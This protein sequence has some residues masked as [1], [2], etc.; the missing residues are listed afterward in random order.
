[1]SFRVGPRRPR[2]T[3]ESTPPRCRRSPADNGET[4]VG[5]A[6]MAPLARVGMALRA[7]L[8]AAPHS[9]VGPAPQGQT[10][11]ITL[12]V[13]LPPATIASAIGASASGMRAEI[14]GL[15]LPAP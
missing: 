9:L 10:V 1:M 8:V 11:R 5:D 4:W 7:P 13:L 15:I 14:N 6:G 12:P 2:A 3:T